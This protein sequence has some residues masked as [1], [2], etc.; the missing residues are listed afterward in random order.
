MGTLLDQVIGT[1]TLRSMDIA[2]YRHDISTL[3]DSKTSGD[4]GT[5]GFT[6]LDDDGRQR[7]P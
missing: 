1:H 3:L 4:Q 5:T 6:S 2:G 7:Q